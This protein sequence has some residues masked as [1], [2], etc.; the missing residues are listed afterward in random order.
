LAD[1]E[2][3]TGI[4]N[5]NTDEVWTGLHHGAMRELSN[6]DGFTAL[7]YFCSVGDFDAIEHLIQVRRSDYLVVEHDGWDCLMFSAY[8]GDV[9]S[10]SLLLQLPRINEHNSVPMA[11]MI[12]VEHEQ[13]QALALID[14]YIADN[15]IAV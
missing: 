9:D 12:A 11:R 13:Y 15:F 7:L 1:A 10:I 14:D 8:L 2:L 3:R 4:D 5:Q 6:R